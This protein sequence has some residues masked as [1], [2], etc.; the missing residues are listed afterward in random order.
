[1]NSP[2]RR[3]EVA[4]AAAMERAAGGDG[5]SSLVVGGEFD[6]FGKRIYMGRERY[7]VLKHIDNGSSCEPLLIKIIYSGSQLGLLLIFYTLISNSSS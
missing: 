1:V 6:C 7:I 4:G 3:P 5:E 2:G